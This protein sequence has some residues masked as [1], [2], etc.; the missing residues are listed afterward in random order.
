[1]C[2]APPD[3]MVV[4]ASSTPTCLGVFGRMV[5]KSDRTRAALALWLNFVSLSESRRAV[6]EII[7]SLEQK[8]RS[9]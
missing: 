5:Y 4:T 3:F 7:L 9:A 8:F 1:M 6:N 2:F